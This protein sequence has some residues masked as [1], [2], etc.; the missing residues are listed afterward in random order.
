MLEVQPSSR[1]VTPTVAGSR[2][3]VPLRVSI[4]N[5]SYSVFILDIVSDAS[6]FALL[7]DTLPHI[8]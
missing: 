2:E 4:S 8:D 7:L 3:I 5:L 6:S 1:D